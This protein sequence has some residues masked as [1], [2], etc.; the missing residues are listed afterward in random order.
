M[1]QL[2]SKAAHSKPNPTNNEVLDAGNIRIGGG[3]RLPT[4]EIL[5]NGRIRIGGGFRLPVA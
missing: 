5:D 3:F 1:T 2:S 4:S